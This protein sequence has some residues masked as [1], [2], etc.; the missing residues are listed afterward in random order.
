[1][2]TPQ[3]P[4]EDDADRHGTAAARVL[5]GLQATRR[6]EGRRI[7]EDSISRAE[8]GMQTLDRLVA[9]AH[10]IRDFGAPRKPQPRRYAKTCGREAWGERCL[11]QIEAG[12]LPA[13]VVRRA[14]RALGEAR[15]DARRTV[16]EFSDLD[17]DM[18]GQGIPQ[19]A[20]LRRLIR[21]TK[22]RRL[23][24]PVR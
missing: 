15:S 11:D 19:V 24:P 20:L 22:R 4:W 14:I 5:W 9:F 10:T 23:K 8:D 13:R 1:M 2:T 18:R 3:A 21:E 6:S 7:L 12:V 17:P 16:Q